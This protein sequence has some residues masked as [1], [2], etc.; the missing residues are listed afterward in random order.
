M[1]YISKVDY[2]RET[3]NVS[4]SRSRLVIYANITFR[5]LK[6]LMESTEVY[7]AEVINDK[8]FVLNTF[9]ICDVL[10]YDDAVEMVSRDRLN[11]IL[12]TDT[13]YITVMVK[14][15]NVKDINTVIYSSRDG[16]ISYVTYNGY[17][18]DIKEAKMFNHREAY[19]QAKYMTKMSKKKG[20]NIL[21]KIREM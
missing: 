2:N 20:N 3:V 11:M 13:E 6:Y 7:G 19:I 12:E 4:E 8:F 10:D 17:S 15:D 21:W 18:S 14:S 5:E 9:D 16:I 1:L